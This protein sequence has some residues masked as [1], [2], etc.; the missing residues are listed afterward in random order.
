MNLF[1]LNPVKPV[2]VIQDV[3]VPFRMAA[4]SIALLLSMGSAQKEHFLQNHFSIDEIAD[5]CVR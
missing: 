5:L 1:Q 3:F 4:Q 2:V